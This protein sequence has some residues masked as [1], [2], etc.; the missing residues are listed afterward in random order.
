MQTVKKSVTKNKNNT[1]SQIRQAVSL[2]KITQFLTHLQY[3]CNTTVKIHRRHHQ[4]RNR[5]CYRQ[6]RPLQ[7]PPQRWHRCCQPICQRH[8]RGWCHHQS[9]QHA[10]DCH[11]RSSIHSR[12]VMAGLWLPG[13]RVSTRTYG[14]WPAARVSPAS[15]C[16]VV[17]GW[18]LCHWFLETTC[19]VVDPCCIS[20]RITCCGPCWRLTRCRSTCNTQ[21]LAT[22]KTLNHLPG[23]HWFPSHWMPIWSLLF[24]SWLTT[25]VFCPCAQMRLLNHSL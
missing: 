4:R 7:R 16:T 8:L 19:S 24:F 9:C 15:S 23:L 22:L 17:R 6:R 11:R 20:H 13:Q 14:N 1:D 10:T 18:D 3:N 25:A 21:T 12:Q 2:W 5:E